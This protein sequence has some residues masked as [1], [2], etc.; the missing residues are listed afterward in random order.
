MNFTNKKVTRTYTTPHKNNCWGAIESM[1]WRKVKKTSTEI[2][3]T[4]PVILPIFQ[5]ACRT[6]LILVK[7]KSMHTKIT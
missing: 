3:R 1:G 7:S 4:S 5:K 2:N 6:I